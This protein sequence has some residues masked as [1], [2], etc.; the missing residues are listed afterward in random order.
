MEGL[1]SGKNKNKAFIPHMS[2]PY[3]HFIVEAVLDTSR[4]QP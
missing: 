2:H 1:G 3:D 4:Q